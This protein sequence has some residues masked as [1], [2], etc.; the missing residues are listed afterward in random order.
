LRVGRRA[1]YGGS[2]AQTSRRG[3]LT[4]DSRRGVPGGC[5]R[6][7]GRVVV[8][9][10]QAR[11]PRLRR[12]AEAGIGRT[13]RGHRPRAPQPEA[14]SRLTLSRS[15]MRR[16]LLLALPLLSLLCGCKALWRDREAI[17]YRPGTPPTTVVADRDATY[18]LCADEPDPGRPSVDVTKGERVG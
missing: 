17:E 18:R 9:V 15:P 3:G 1:G 5:R 2:V 8:L 11:R 16:A 4:R 6:G 10:P 7:P 14:L 13:Q 12:R